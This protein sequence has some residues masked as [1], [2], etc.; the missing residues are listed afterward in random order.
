MESSVEGRSSMRQVYVV[1]G[2]RLTP[3]KYLEVKS[4]DPGAT[5]LHVDAQLRVDALAAICRQAPVDLVIFSGGATAG[6]GLPTEA[7]S[8]WTKFLRADYGSHR[9]AILLEDESL[10]T[11]ENA[12][13]VQRMVERVQY[14]VLHVITSGYHVQRAREIFQKQG[15]HVE[16][17]AAEDVV[18]NLITSRKAEM[19]Q[20]KKS[21]RVWGERLREWVARK[22]PRRFL[23]SIS[24]AYRK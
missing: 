10:N 1:L 6:F 16:V 5:A 19:R 21:F 18:A 3:E 8:L 13:N 2:K 9:P 23:T 12:A 14:F 24:H 20:Y 4:K 11:V 22:L 7:H 17:L 15:L